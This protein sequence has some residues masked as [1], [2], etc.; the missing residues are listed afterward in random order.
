MVMMM[1][2]L[3]CSQM[4]EVQPQWKTVV[5][6]YKQHHAGTRGR[7]QVCAAENEIPILVIYLRRCKSWPGNSFLS[8]LEPPGA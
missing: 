3:F 6:W 4:G 5:Y 8:N 7:D 2:I 1:T